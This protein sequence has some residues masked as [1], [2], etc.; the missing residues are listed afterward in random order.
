MDSQ[1][2]ESRYR[3]G[4]GGGRGEEGRG[5]RSIREAV[6]PQGLEPVKT[7]FAHPKLWVA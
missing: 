2:S 5:V 4:G 3:E 1:S 6:Q 7:P